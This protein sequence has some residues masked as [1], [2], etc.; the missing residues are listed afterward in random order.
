[1]GHGER[2]IRKLDLPPIET[3]TFGI[4]G[5]LII[6]LGTE[7]KVTVEGQ[8]NMQDILKTKVENGNWNIVFDKCVNLHEAFDITVT[9][10][11]LQAVVL[12]GSGTI[13]MEDL[14][15]SER[16]RAILTGSGIINIKVN[17]EQVDAEILGSGNIDVEGLAD[18]LQVT[19]S[20]SGTIDT[21]SM[22]ATTANVEVSG[23]GEVFVE[24]LDELSILITGTGNVTYRGNPIVN[25]NIIGTGQVF[26]TN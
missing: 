25:S 5:N 9:L 24:V 18:F 19:L 22:I 17:A 13:V 21:Y 15:E 6:R 1:M 16:F 14:L 4:A 2:V 3:I 26:K 10:P 12:S 23:S 7:Q 8:A 20:G 11:S